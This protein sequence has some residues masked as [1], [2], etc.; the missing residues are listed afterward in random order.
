M[1]A[2]KGSM[3]NRVRVG[4]VSAIAAGL[5]F[6]IAGPAQTQTLPT[7]TGTSTLSVVPATLDLSGLPA[8]L[9]TTIGTLVAQATNTGDPVARLALGGLGAAGQTAP[10]L[11]VTS[12]DGDRSGNEQRSAGAAGVEATLGL[13]DYAVQSG[14]DTATASVAALAGEITTPLGL[15]ASLDAQQ[16]GATATPTGT[17][18]KVALTVTGLEVGLDDLLPADLLAALPLDIVLDLVA[19]LGLPIPADLT[20]QI[21][22]VDALVTTLQDAVDAAGDLAA[23][24]ALLDDALTTDTAVA[25]AQDAVDAAQATVDQLAAQ[26]AQ[27][28]AQIATTESS[29]ASLEDQKSALDPLTQFTQITQLTAQITSLQTTLSSLQSQA[30]TTATALTAAEADL[31]A[32]EALLDDAIAAA[33][34]LDP[35]IVALVDQL[36]ALEALLDGLLADLD[37]LLGGLDLANLRLDLLDALTGAPL[38]DLGRLDLGLLTSADGLASTGAVTCAVSDL[39]VLGTAVPA[40]ECGDIGTAL[41]GLAAAIGDALAVLP[42]T[43]PVPT[44]TAGGLDMASSGAGTPNADGVSTAFARVTALTLDI[45]PVQLTSVVDDLVAELEALIGELDTLVAGLD[46]AGVVPLALGGTAP[47][48]AS[49][50][51]PVTLGEA[52]AELQDVLATLPT[53]D[54]LDGL[55][56]LG[57]TTALGAV[58]LGS[59]FTAQSAAVPAQPNTPAGPDT[60]ANPSGP[61]TPS[62]PT[63]LPTTGFGLHTVLMA[64]LAALAAGGVTVG[65]GRGVGLGLHRRPGLADG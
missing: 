9:D 12:A 40:P 25:A 53:G 52:L 28:A 21:G 30:A 8:D 49:L 20:D 16:L 5:V 48:A 31:A 44:V 13:V 11:D 61:A 41:D 63:S 59:T 42:V 22:D 65:L 50:A 43:A 38:L 4:V 3:R 60:P 47:G 62:G 35:A 18:S 24:Q 58:D 51:V 7:G 56:T 29:I 37:G 45:A 54:A 19:S 33:A 1:H 34:D 55:G 46:V 6:G 36:A 27:I 15:G 39:V 64:A 14:A 23:T 2:V 17:A 32:A 26:A 10:A 57:L